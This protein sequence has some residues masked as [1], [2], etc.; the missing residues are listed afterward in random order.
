MLISAVSTIHPPP[1]LLCHP[2]P[3]PPSEPHPARPRPSA[4]AAA[5]AAVVV[6]L[7][8]RRGD[9][10]EEREGTPCIQCTYKS[11]RTKVA[12]GCR[13]EHVSPSRASA[14]A[15]KRQRV[16]PRLRCRID[17]YA[18]C[19]QHTQTHIH[20]VQ[21]MFVQVHYLSL[22][23]H[24]YIAY[25]HTYHNNNHSRRRSRSRSLGAARTAVI[26]HRCRRG[27]AKR[28]QR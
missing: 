2:P 1:I 7:Q 3:S 10:E 21:S 9:R 15:R 5:A 22:S 24:I 6:I 19:V 12:S 14:C 4:A 27:G 11:R 16:S 17:T 23:V 8:S 25:R 13:F 18:C 28:G 20:N 26:G